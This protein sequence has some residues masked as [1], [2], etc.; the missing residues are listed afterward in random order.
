[1]KDARFDRSLRDILDLGDLCVRHVLEKRH[2]HRDPLVSGQL[3]DTIPDTG[4]ILRGCDDS[5]GIGCLVGQ[6]FIGRC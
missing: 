4:C 3:V 5:L 6:V 1:M 2:V